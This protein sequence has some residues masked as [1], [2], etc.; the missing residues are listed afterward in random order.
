MKA[1]RP[2]GEKEAAS[3]ERRSPLESAILN[4]GLALALEWGEQWLTPIQERLGAMHP[5]LS[6]SD[7]DA[8]DEACRAAM[9]FGHRQV[10]ICWREA[11][12]DRDATFTRWRDDVLAKHPWM[13]EENLGRLFSQGMYYAWK[14]GDV[15]FE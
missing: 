4:E 12:P 15:G 7:L 1:K 14:N 3:P 13:S 8:Y 10:P 9:R 11:G 6:P 5:L 2:R